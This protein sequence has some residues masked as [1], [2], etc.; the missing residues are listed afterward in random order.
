[1]KDIYSH[2]GHRNQWNRWKGAA[3]VSRRKRRIRLAAGI[4]ILAAL[5]GIY[6][7]VRQAASRYEEAQAEKPLLL[8]L[9]ADRISAVGY[10]SLSG[11]AV[12]FVRQDGIWEF[13]PDEGEMPGEE[14]DQTAAGALAASL[15]GIRLIQTMNGVED[16]AEYGLAEPRYTVTVE[17]TSGTVTKIAI[18]DDNEAAGTVYCM[19]NGDTSAVYAVSPAITANLHKTAEEYLPDTDSTADAGSAAEPAEQEE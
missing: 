10:T 15:T 19:V 14:P 12:S 13:A 3:D 18:G 11:N 7:A 9:T 4:L 16:L 5:A 1:M 8:D 6:A 2:S 17:D